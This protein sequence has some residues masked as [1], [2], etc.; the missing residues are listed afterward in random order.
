M[1][2][3][4]FCTKSFNF[5]NTGEVNS[6]K[7]AGSV[8]TK[9]RESKVRRTNK[10]SSLVDRKGTICDKKCWGNSVPPVKEKINQKRDEMRKM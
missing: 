3:A 7:K 10:Q 4:S 8:A 1:C 9:T 6:K 5:A 2:G